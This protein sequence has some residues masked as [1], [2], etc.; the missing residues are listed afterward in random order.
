MSVPS[1]PPSQQWWTIRGD[2]IMA[3]LAKVQQGDEPW[4]VYAELLV[5]AE[6]TDYGRG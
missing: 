4:V 1:R 6:T 5:N 3:A 2:D